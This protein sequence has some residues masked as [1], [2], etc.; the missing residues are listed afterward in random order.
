MVSFSTLFEINVLQKLRCGPSF[1]FIVYQ[2]F[3]D[4]FLALG[5]DVGDLVGKSLK[6]L[7]REVDFHVSCMFSEVLQDMFAGGPSDVMDFVDLVQFIVAREQR[8]Q[9][10]HFVHHAAY[11]PDVHLVAIVSVS[12]QT[13]RRPVPSCRNVLGQR[14]VLVDAPA[15]AEVC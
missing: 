5:R 6:F 3:P 4:K 10:Q 8:T 11:A 1:V 15:A 13:F 9:T 14:L 12:E 7:G 2:H